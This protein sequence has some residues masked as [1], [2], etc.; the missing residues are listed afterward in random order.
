MTMKTLKENNTLGQLLELNASSY[1]TLC[2][3]CAI[4]ESIL[5]F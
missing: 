2:T 3:Y 5:Y 1:C 4:F